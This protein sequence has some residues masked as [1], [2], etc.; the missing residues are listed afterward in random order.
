MVSFLAVGHLECSEA[1]RKTRLL[2]WRPFIFENQRLPNL[3]I[4]ANTPKG[5]F[6]FQNKGIISI[7]S[8]V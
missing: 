2:L 6:D 1:G 8:T 4:F 5:R 3:K 7:V